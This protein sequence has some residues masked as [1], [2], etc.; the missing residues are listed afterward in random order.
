MTSR[1]S[2][3]RETDFP[4]TKVMV[5]GGH[6]EGILAYDKMLEQAGERLLAVLRGVEG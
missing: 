4:R 1:I 5:M 3:F 6:E 2:T